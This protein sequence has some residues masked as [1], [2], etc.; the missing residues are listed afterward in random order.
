MA[1]EERNVERLKIAALTLLLILLTSKLY[2]LSQA[3]DHHKESIRE[4]KAAIIE[5]CGTDRI[6]ELE[7]E[8]EITK[9]I[10]NRLTEQ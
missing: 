3:Q 7:R 8:L 10:L 6:D 9:A 4:I 2:Y 1:T 5:A